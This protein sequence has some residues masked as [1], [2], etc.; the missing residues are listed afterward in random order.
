MSTITSNSIINNFEEQRDQ[1]RL[2]AIKKFEKLA[3]KKYG[4]V[5]GLFSAVFL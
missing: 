5:E 3:I 1:M 4:S 2:I